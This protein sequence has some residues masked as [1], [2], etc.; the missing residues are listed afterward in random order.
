MLLVILSGCGEIDVHLQPPTSGLRAPVPGGNHRQIVM[1]EYFTDNRTGQLCGMKKYGNASVTCRGNP[2]QWLAAL[3]ANEL[4]ASGF[5]VLSDK[6]IVRD[7]ALRLDGVLL[8]LFAEPVLGYWST[9]VETD[10]SVTL[11]ATSK[12]GLHAERTFFV[13]GEST[14]YISPQF[15]FNSSLK[16]GVRQLMGKMVE[17]ILELM[18]QYPQLGLSHHHPTIVA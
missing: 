6:E 2:A 9:T 15:I 16:D 14:S 5:T 18:R 4:R 11:V 10:L 7:N 3:L 1:P 13:K 8:T 17:A 12:T